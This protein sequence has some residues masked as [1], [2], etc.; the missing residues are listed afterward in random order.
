[1]SV[2]IRAAERR[3]ADG[4]YEQWERVRQ[5]NA[6]LDPRIVPAPVS[7]VE[8]R[9]ALDAILGREGAATFVA[10]DS[11]TL[12]GFVRGVIELQQPDRLPERH[13]SIGYLYVAPTHRRQGIG[14][15]LFEAVAA[16]AATH[17]GVRHFE[18]TVLAK[19]DEAAAFWRQ[20]GFTPFIQRLWAPLPGTGA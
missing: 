1:M 13:A 9:A 16:W 14:R 4:L 8:F 12:V 19:D 10:E 17:D 6:S 7:L 5:Y 2:A 20:L 15:R 18:M 3:D 11:G